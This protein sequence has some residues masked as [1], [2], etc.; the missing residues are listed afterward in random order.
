MPR[1]ETRPCGSPFSR[2]ANLSVYLTGCPSCVSHLA[3]ADIDDECVVYLGNRK[4]LAFANAEDRQ[5]RLNRQV[6]K[7]VE[8]FFPLW[9]LEKVTHADLED[10]I[11]VT[12][13]DDEPTRALWFR[14]TVAT[15]C[16]WPLFI[17]DAVDHYGPAQLLGSMDQV[18]CQW[19]EQLMTGPQL[20]F[21]IE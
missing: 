20:V 17:R 6:M 7:N 3:E 9:F 11:E 2:A 14:E 1:I 8:S 10:M 16:G 13:M 12:Q 4:Y 15:T 21:R 5:R 18:G 19:D